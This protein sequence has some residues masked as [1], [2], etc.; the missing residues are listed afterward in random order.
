MAGAERWLAMQAQ[1]NSRYPRASHESFHA[2]D[3]DENRTP[4][5]V[6]RTA[7]RRHQAAGGKH[8]VVC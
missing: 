1:N 5:S 7:G 2:Q 6:R 8:P 3:V 4:P